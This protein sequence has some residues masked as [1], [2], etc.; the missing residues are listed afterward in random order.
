LGGW[1][2]LEEWLVWRGWGRGRGRGGRGLLEEEGE[3]LPDPEDWLCML[4]DCCGHIIIGG[5]K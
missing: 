3:L 5:G 4:T 1:G 2:W